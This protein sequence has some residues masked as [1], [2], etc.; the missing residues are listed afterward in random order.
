M[1]YLKCVLEDILILPEEITA[2]HIAKFNSPQFN[3]SFKQLEVLPG[4]IGNLTQL[5]SLELFGNELK[6]LPP[7]LTN[8]KKLKTLGL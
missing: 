5:Q 7:R 1:A 3:L 2:E 4:R 6:S 8:L